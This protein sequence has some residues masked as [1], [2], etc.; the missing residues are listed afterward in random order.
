MPT[1]VIANLKSKSIHCADKRESLLHILL[2]STDW[3]HA[4]GGKGRC[5]TCKARIIE[6]MDH[7]TAR[8][9]PEEQYMKMNKLQ[10][11]ERLT[12]QTFPLGDVTVEVPKETQLPHLTYTK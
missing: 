11:D 12:C 2:T 8:T 3:M 10:V 7:L 9:K 6:G 5:T 1:I 4:C